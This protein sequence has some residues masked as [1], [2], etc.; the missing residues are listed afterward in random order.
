MPGRTGFALVID[1]VLAPNCQLFLTHGLW[2][3][4]IDVLLRPEDLKRIGEKVCLCNYLCG[5]VL[6]PA[7]NLNAM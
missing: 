5:G 6:V 7:G 4:R 2:L 1:A 3:V